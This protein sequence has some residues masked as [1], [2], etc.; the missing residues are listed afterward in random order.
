VR[1][2][3]SRERARIGVAR[4]RAF[5]FYYEDNLEL[6]RLQGAALVEFSP[7]VDQAL[8]S[9]LD[10]IYFGGGYP[11]LHGEALSANTSMRVAVAQFVARDGPVYAECGGFMYLCEAIVDGEGCVWPMA[12][13][14][15]SKARMQSRPARLGYIEVETISEAGW[16]PGG[17]R[18]RGH[19][20]RYSAIDPMPENIQRV[21][22]SPAEAFRVHAAMGSYVHVHFRS[23]P[24]WAEAFVDA[25]EQWRITRESEAS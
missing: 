12:A 15:P 16:L 25:C 14:F 10:G 18:A 7:T 22:R 20:F 4:D 17:L 5:C 8:P 13:I 6:L 24:H 11:E 3:G 21:Y 9:G 2:T 19:E 1:K 23:S